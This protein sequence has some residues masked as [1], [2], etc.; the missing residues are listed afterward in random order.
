MTFALNST[1]YETYPLR[2]F[3]ED[4]E[5][6]YLMKVPPSYPGSESQSSSSAEE[7]KSLKQECLTRQ[8]LDRKQHKLEDLR[9]SIVF[10]VVGFVLFFVHFPTARKISKEK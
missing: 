6:A 7:N 10:T 9:N 2:F 5:N 4:C 1:Q 3:G 8:E